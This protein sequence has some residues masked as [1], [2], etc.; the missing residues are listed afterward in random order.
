MGKLILAEQSL[1]RQTHLGY[2][3]ATAEYGE[4]WGRT[5]AKLVTVLASTPSNDRFF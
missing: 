5:G 2:Q 4:A 1:E 3:L